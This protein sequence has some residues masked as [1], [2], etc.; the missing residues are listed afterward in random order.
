MLLKRSIIIHILLLVLLTQS[1]CGRFFGKDDALLKGRTVSVA[2]TVPESP[3]PAAKP[4]K[5]SPPVKSSGPQNSVA[6]DSKLLPSEESSSTYPLFYLDI[7]PLKDLPAQRRYDKTQFSDLVVEKGIINED[8]VWRGAVLIKKSLVVTPQ[9]TLRIE[10]GAVVRFAPAEQ[11]QQ[12][13]RLVVQGRLVS[14]GTLSRPV[15]I[16]SAYP[17]PQ[18]SDWGGIVLLGS[19]KKNSFE[20]TLITGAINA[21]DARHSSLSVRAIKISDSLLGISVNDS[22]ASIHSADISRT[23]T[24]LYFS[25]SEVEMREL[26]LRQNRLGILGLR[27]S[28]TISSSTV[29]SNAQE[30]IVADSCRFRINGS[31]FTKNRTGAFIKSGEGQIQQCSFSENTE[32]GLA[33]V[34]CK[35]R[36]QS[37]SFRSNQYSGIMIDSARGS[38]SGSLFTFNSGPNIVFKGN[39][40][41]SLIL[42]FWD[43]LDEKTIQSSIR[44]QKSALNRLDITPVLTEKPPLAP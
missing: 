14:A 23:D 10:P 29:Q 25:D 1:G 15:T 18:P 19:E 27:S 4:V 9:A 33:L 38:V 3:P 40:S 36:I 28:F 21:I 16:S 31:H 5:E 34:A 8:T 7:H 32:S 11:G 22:T 43:T 26:K 37:A 24:A 35:A 42:N 12:P 13:L 17:S 41:F 44:Y 20:H 30:G 2:V 39:E 6:I